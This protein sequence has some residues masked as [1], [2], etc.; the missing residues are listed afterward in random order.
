MKTYI[1]P[2]SSILVMTGNSIICASG[3]NRV[4]VAGES[5]TIPENSIGD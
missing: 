5:E 1:K 4:G 2:F 3:P